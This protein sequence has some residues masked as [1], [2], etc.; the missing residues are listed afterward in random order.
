MWTK[1]F[2]Q[3]AAERAVKTAIQT[4]LAVVSSAAT[5]ATMSGGD[6]GLAL[7]TAGFAALFSIA[8]SIAS[9]R[10]GDRATAAAL[11]VAAPGGRHSRTD[12]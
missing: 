1:T 11:P 12:E 7:K 2:W 10:V 9:A 8:T 4:L 5:A 3:D 6:W